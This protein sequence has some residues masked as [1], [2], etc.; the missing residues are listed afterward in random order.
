M[1]RGKS[2]V[3]CSGNLMERSAHPA[4]P[5]LTCIGA[6]RPERFSAR[7]LWHSTE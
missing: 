1:H 4:M 6:R 5:S 2:E 7:N 3:S